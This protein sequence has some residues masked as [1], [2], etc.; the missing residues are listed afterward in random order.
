M[1]ITFEY[2]HLSASFYIIH[3]VIPI[4]ILRLNK[5]TDTANGAA[6]LINLFIELVIYYSGGESSGYTVAQRA[7][8]AVLCSAG[9]AEVYDEFCDNIIV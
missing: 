1:C 4:L 2:N 5:E 9:S 7:V 6:N 3:D 8:A